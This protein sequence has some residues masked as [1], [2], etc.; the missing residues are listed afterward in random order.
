[1]LGV[2]LGA[3]PSLF[4]TVG[5]KKNKRKR[6]EKKREGEKEK[7]QGEKREI[8][9]MFLQCGLVNSRMN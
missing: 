2:I 8:N 4:Q 3:N 9:V 1:M 5:F 6:R 7:K